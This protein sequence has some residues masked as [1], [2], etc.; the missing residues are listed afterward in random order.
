MSDERSKRPP[1]ITFDGDVSNSQLGRMKTPSTPIP[2]NNAR[3]KAALNITYAGEV[4]N[5]K[6]GR[7]QAQTRHNFINGVERMARTP[8]Q[9]T[10]VDKRLQAIETRAMHYVQQHKAQ[11][12]ARTTPQA[13]QRG[14]RQQTPTP[15][16]QSPGRMRAL[17]SRAATQVKTLRE[18]GRATIDR[19]AGPRDNRRS[20]VQ[21]RAPQPTKEKQHGR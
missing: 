13:A 9:Q 17:M 14:A 1:A 18:K 19:L 21:S 3:S 15:P 5:A 8:Q 12:A 6:L 2:T 4:S 11:T 16:T 10:A 20:T 7:L